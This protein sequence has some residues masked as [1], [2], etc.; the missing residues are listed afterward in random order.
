MSK[1][2]KQELITPSDYLVAWANG[3]LTFEEA[4]SDY[5]AKAY[6]TGLSEGIASAQEA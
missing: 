1:K 2:L 5:A 3:E 6:A 4:L